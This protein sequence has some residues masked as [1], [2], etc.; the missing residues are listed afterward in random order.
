MNL[1]L[2]QQTTNVGRRILSFITGIHNLTWAT[3]GFFELQCENKNVGVD[4][5]KSTLVLLNTEKSTLMYNFLIEI[6][7]TSTL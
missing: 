1:L 4:A 5:K 3:R 7:I 2:I 6:A